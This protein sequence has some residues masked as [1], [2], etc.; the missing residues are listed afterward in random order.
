AAQG[1]VA[2]PAEMPAL[3]PLARHPGGGIAPAAP[4]APK[5]LPP[6]S[7]ITIT[8]PQNLPPELFRALMDYADR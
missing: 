1:P 3:P 4:A 7:T 8:D 6:G 5:A 2:A